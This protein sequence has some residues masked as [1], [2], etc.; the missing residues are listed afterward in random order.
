MWW[1]AWPTSG[2]PPVL[3]TRAEFDAMVADL[4]AA[5]LVDDAT[6]LYWDLRPSVRYPTVEFR[7]ADT[8]TDLDDA[9]LH[10]AL[11]RSLVRT[12][13][14]RLAAGAPV[15]DV[16]DAYLRAARW[17]AA[18][19]GTDGE[20]CDPVSGGLVPAPLAFRNFLH[21][22]EP[23]LREHDEYRTVRE[24]LNGLLARGTSAR[25][26]RSCYA[27]SGDLRDVVR[28]LVSRTGS[29]LAPV[30]P[31]AAADEPLTPRTEAPAPAAHRPRTRRRRPAGAAP[32]RSRPSR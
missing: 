4:V 2:P 18:R 26:Q 24:L 8:C 25:Q 32:H 13:A 16:T 30:P 29:V 12:L 31:V 19:F 9:V 1:S 17:R 11:A 28:W 6:T 5:D 27:A 3:C 23:D 14:G 15:P 10:A 22:L 21:E 7:V 20:L